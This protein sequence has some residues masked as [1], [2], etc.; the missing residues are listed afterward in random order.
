MALIRPEVTAALLRGREVIIGMIIL[1]GG[2]WLIGLGGYLLV[3]VGL[4]IAAL[5]LGWAVLAWRRLKFAQDGD[6][7][8]VVEVDEGQIGYLG[9][10]VGGFVSLPDLVEVRLVTMRGRRLWR[11]KQSDGQALLV[12]VDA[13]GAER[14]FDAFAALP[15]MD[16]AALVSALDS[17][18]HTGSRALSVAGE[19]K[20]IWV[21][22]GRAVLR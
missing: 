19:T 18:P 1:A 7:P 16:T 11:L 5:G 10:N 3:P 13:T 15:G 14:L 8:G 21:R 20:V 2:L 4:A 17:A 22:K 9:P 6:A 12:P